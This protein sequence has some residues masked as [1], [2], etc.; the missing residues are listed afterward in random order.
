M[1]AKRKRSAT[2]DTNDLFAAN[3][4]VLQT[5]NISGAK[6]L[7]LLAQAAGHVET[8]WGEAH[9]ADGLGLA[10][11]YMRDGFGVSVYSSNMDLPQRGDLLGCRFDATYTADPA[12]AWEF[13]KG[14]LDAGNP[15][16]MA[17]PEDSI[18][19]A[20]KDAKDID[21]RSLMARGVGGPALEG[22]V[23]WESFANYVPEWVPLGG[24]GLY[25]LAKT[26]PKPALAKAVRI[27]AKRVVD[28]QDHHPSVGRFGEA[29]NFGVSA[30]EQFLADLLQPEIDIPGAEGG[31][32]P[33]NFQHNARSA[34]AEYFADAAE[35]LSG[36]TASILADVA[37]DYRVA[38]EGI[39]R[40]GNEGLGKKRHAKAGQKAIKQTIGASLEAEKRILDHMQTLAG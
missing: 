18:A 40:F 19:Y 20:Y 29:S 8:T 33:I 22:T 4:A 37:E 36:P 11:C 38:A 23:S 13:V 7:F 2:V 27:L 31:C 3:F 12:E 26:V 17:G 9:A 16:K 39:R 15:V 14:G 28:W 10:F 34:L 32:T 5:H 21:G 24:G 6:V 25:R 35:K 1:A 30:L